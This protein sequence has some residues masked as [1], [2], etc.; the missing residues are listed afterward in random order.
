[1]EINNVSSALQI[2]IILMLQIQV[3]ILVISTKIPPFVPA[4]EDQKDSP[5]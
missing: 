4:S 5:K 2:I 3:L 1:M